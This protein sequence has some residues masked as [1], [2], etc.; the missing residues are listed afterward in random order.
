MKFSV[1]NWRLALALVAAALP[2]SPGLLADATVLPNQ[3]TYT[4]FESGQVRPLALSPSR[5]M[6]FAVN[7]PDS[8][9]EVFA[10]TRGGI[11]HCGS[12]SVGLE[13]VAV[14]ARG[15]KEVWVVNHLSDSVSIVRLRDA[16][17]GQGDEDG[18]DRKSTR[19]GPVG[20]V[21]RTLLV[22]DEPRDIVFGGPQRDRAFITTAHRGQNSARDP[23]LTVPGVGR[24]DVWVF[25]ADRLGNTLEGRPLN[26]ITLFTDTPR[27]LAVS[28]D[29]RRVY[30][31]GFH[32]GNRT[33]T[34]H[35]RIVTP[36]GGTPGPHTNF[37]GIAQPETGL[38]VR[39]NGE[40]WVDES[41]RSWDDQVKFSLPDKDVFV[42]DATA[43]PPAPVAGADGYFQGVGATIFNMVV[44][45]RTGSVYV[46][47]TDAQNF[48][49]FEGPGMFAGQ[50]VRGHLHESRISVLAD[51]AVLP[52]H[53][54]K[55]IDY[56]TCCAPIP[57]SVNDRSL[58]FPM[59]MAVT[60]DGGTLYVTAFG[61]SKIGVF[62][63]R[64]LESDTFV[65]NAADHIELSGG[66]P[67]GVV[68]D[69]ARGRL[70][71]LTRFD[72]SVKVIDTARRR[73][74]AQVAMHNPEPAHI[75]T[76]RRFLYDARLSSSHGD[77][78][79]AS[80]HV[81]GDLDSLAWDLGN[82]DGTEINNPGPFVVRPSDVGFNHIPV[83]FRPMKGPMT[84]QSLRG[85]ANH[86]SMH[87]RG[88]RNGGNLE[89]NA[90]PDGGVYNEEEAFRQF[91]PAFV[92]LLGRHATLS[93]E[94]MQAFTDFALEIM[95]PP[96]P[97]RPLDNTL[98]P[99]QQA[100]HDFFFGGLADPFAPCSGCH[101]V[102]PR[103]NA[104]H[105]VKKPGFFGADGRAT[106]ELEPQVFK[107]PHLRNMYQK[108]GM[109][110]MGKAPD[111]FFPEFDD[112]NVDNAFMGDQVRGFGFFHDG[113]VDTVFR[114]LK[115]R[116]FQNSGPESPFPNPGGFAVGPVGDLQRREVE[117][118]LMAFD[119]NFAPI[120][121]QQVT[122]GRD[123]EAV[124]APRLA[125]LMTR[126]DA[127]DCD[128][129][130]K[131]RHAKREAGY[132]YI[133][134][135]LF[136]SDRSDEALLTSE[137]LRRRARAPSGE[138]TFTCV[139]P[140]SGMRIGIDRDED[141]I[142]DGDELSVG[143]NPADRVSRR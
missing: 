126:A 74:V 91:N 113:S 120:L 48:K 42:I 83:H 49:R 59:D 108:V 127:G 70:Y 39:F 103:G 65:P 18:H 71:V 34:L 5:R 90:Q 21:V 22:G 61:S 50:T 66:G 29:G 82:P 3:S 92:G 133:G 20:H 117:E 2:V 44:N 140:L 86:G 129:V 73:E 95:Y 105:G 13:P 64:Q 41:G 122:L 37:E 115:I 27:A 55:H 8:R 53:L 16:A 89:P 23:Q 11:R 139:P 78:A 85:L 84:T 124:V 7:T 106:F 77:S 130:A 38:I 107:I 116:F 67:S 142:F 69:E 123:S 134:G 25:D 54:N 36:N 52:R 57:N 81:F 17:C 58:A 45:P 28:A 109:F 88:D 102:D 119:T 131:G 47:N 104:E 46:A 15:D 75:V 26:V 1:S 43:N 40:H 114:F 31:A 4:L 93:A 63:T 110:G 76:G 98:T 112:P 111:F 99:R 128:L 138:I 135:G 6:L 62:D 30:A 33:T 125:L 10:V 136:R 100:G 97:V 19:P 141:G 24:A 87:W 132:L 143:S 51:G 9:L 94:D 12:V 68:L 32:T 101:M 79:C 35:E 118:F 137:A 14:A 56:S 60:R 121:G 96:N 72:N 80:C